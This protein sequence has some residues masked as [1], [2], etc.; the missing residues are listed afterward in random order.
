LSSQIEYSAVC[1]HTLQWRSSFL[2]CTFS[3]ASQAPEQEGKRLHPSVVLCAL[4]IDTDTLW[5]YSG[6]G[7]GLD[8]LKERAGGLKGIEGLDLTTGD[9]S[10][11]SFSTYPRMR[12]ERLYHDSTECHGCHLYAPWITATKLH[13]QI[14]YFPA[15]RTLS[16]TWP[17]GPYLPRQTCTNDLSTRGATTRGY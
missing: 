2:S 13:T 6:P 8:D 12:I 9:L 7:Q 14:P 10:T 3:L 17:L 16:S 1:S 11:M 4:H 5:Y 15:Y